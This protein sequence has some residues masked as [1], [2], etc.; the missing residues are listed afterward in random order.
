MARIKSSDSTSKR[1]VIIKEATKLFKDRGFAASSMRD[2]A[3]H[4]GVE[5]PSLYN[6]IQSKTELLN[7]ICFNVANRFTQKIS[8]VE[9]EKLSVIAKT[10]K[11]L[12][13]HIQEMIHN[14]GEVY[15]SDRE[16]RNMKDPELTE[17]RELRRNYRRRFSQIIQKGIDDNEIKDI[18]ANTAV[19][20]FLNSIA[21]V[22]QWHRILHKVSSI[23]LENNM[24]TIMINGIKHKE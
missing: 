21:A 7:I 9:T 18:D 1:E 20:I 23:E 15:V 6:H 8:E 24:I 19:M 4:V 11:L 22:D 3:E 2:L 5:A 17:F 16:W 10:E 12:R 13:F 14:Y